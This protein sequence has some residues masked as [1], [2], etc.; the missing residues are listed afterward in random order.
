M[1]RI[2]KSNY[3]NVGITKHIKANAPSNKKSVEAKTMEIHQAQSLEEKANSIIEDAKQ[4]YLRIIDEANYEAQ[5]IL[6]NAQYEKETIYK[7]SAEQGYNKGYDLGYSEG[8]G[9]AE[10]I[11]HQATELKQQ[12]DERSIRIYKE[13]EIEIM[14]MVLDIARK[15][16]GE[17]LT[18]NPEFML[19]LIKQALSKCAFKD[20]LV[21]RVSEQDY[22]YVN[23]NKNNIIMLTEGINNLD[24]YCDK[25]LQKGSCIVE[26]T[27]GE[28]NS[29]INIQMNEIQK[30]FEYMMRN[31]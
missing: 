4:M 23:K 2:F 16:I 5:K 30:A 11:I 10:A 8:L 24:I 29:G 21:I 31:E 6:E 25:A 13:A 15:V 3:V 26:T 9:K 19:S 20:K 7:L 14:S 12:L 22:D 27:S 28:I 18:Q 17:E 1:S